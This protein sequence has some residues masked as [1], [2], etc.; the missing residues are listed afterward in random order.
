[1]VA[2]TNEDGD[3]VELPNDGSA[4]GDNR[5]G[6]I[7]EYIP[8]I[9]YGSMKLVE[10]LSPQCTYTNYYAELVLS[11][12]Q[13]ELISNETILTKALSYN[14]R[15]TLYSTSFTREWENGR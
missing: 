3:P 12:Q 13:I 5:T 8:N 4:N 9:A 2:Y 6:S 10:D 14:V 11:Q 15:E 1:M 7:L